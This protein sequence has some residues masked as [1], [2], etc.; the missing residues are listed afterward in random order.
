VPHAELPQAFN[1]R[2]HFLASANNQPVGEGYPHFLSAETL[3]GFRARR[4]V[5]LLQ[6]TEKLTAEDFARMQVDQYCAPARTFCDLLEHLR[7]AILVQPALKD[8]HDEAVRALDVLQGWDHYLTADSVAGAIYELTQY[9]AMRRLFEPWLGELT[10]HVIGIG[11]HPLLAPTIGPFVD[12]SP[13]VMRRMLCNDEKDWF[14]DADGHSLTREAVLALAFRDALNH[15]RDRLGPELAD[16]EW[17]AIHMVT[18]GHI[19]GHNRTLARLFN[20]GPYP[21]GGDMNTVW[22]ASY[23]PK[24]P[25]DQRWCFSASWRQIIDVGDWDNS[26]GMNVPGQSG[27][28]ASRHYADFIPRWLKGEYHPLPWSRARVEE[29]AKARLRLEP[30]AA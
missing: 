4:I 7:P 25:L 3:N 24:V 9:F 2:E 19:L 28:P 20:R 21:L 16:W 30:A 29:H 17:G 1:P 26:R 15:L 12:R 22:Q 18:F 23:L 27:H 14:R 13:V 5:D 10:D 11:F 8:C 6:A